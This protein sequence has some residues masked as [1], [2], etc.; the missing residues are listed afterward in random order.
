MHSGAVYEF[1]SELIRRRTPSGARRRRAFAAPGAVWKRVL[2]FEGCAPLFS[3]RLADAGLEREIPRELQL[4]LRD[5]RS[6]S[7]QSSLLIDRQMPAVA[8]MATEH[9]IRAMVL[10]GAARILGGETPGGR[11]VADVD[12]LV[13]PA[14]AARFHLLLQS[15]LGYRAAGA[16]AAHHLPGLV[17]PGC[18]GIEV[19]FRLAER[20]S[21]LDETIW[22]GT[23]TIAAGSHSIE[24][25][26][27]T[28]LLL[29]T[30][31]HAAA[32][33]WNVRYRLRD[34]CDV[35][36]LCGDDVSGERL[37]EYVRSHRERRALETLLS[38]AHDLEP[39][40]PRSRNGAWATVRRVSIA[41]LALAV[42][43]KERLMAERLFRYAGV[44]A[45]GSPRAILRSGAGIVRRLC[46]VAV[47]RTLPAPARTVRAVAALLIVALAGCSDPAGS[48]PE[49]A[50][51]FLFISNETAPRGIHLFEHDSVRRLSGA[52]HEDVHPHSAAGRI[53]FTSFRDGNA[54]IYSSDAGLAG[55]QRLTADPWS[56]TRPALDPSGTTIA[57][58]TNRTGA[59]RVW[60]MNADGTNQRALETGSGSFVPEGA[61]A[62]RGA[63][64]QIA[65][66]STRTGT[67]QVYV[68]ARTGGSAIQ[69]SHEAPGAFLP[70]WTGDGSAVLYTTEAGQATVR[71]V[72]RTGGDWRVLA[73]TD[74]PL[75]GASCRE[76]RC[77]S[78]AGVEGAGEIVIVERIGGVPRVVVGG[79]SDSSDSS[80]PAFLV[81]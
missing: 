57:F 45:E 36:E 68:V 62:W 66:T 10:K 81:R 69:L 6:K 23:R 22:E 65:F 27:A 67:S 40:L 39:R 58:V 30:L 50:P 64:N 28:S 75:R 12:L 37:A 11:S 24:I 16:G 4:L 9:G 51:P 78:V 48:R 33:N 73:S 56:D 53:V 7:L 76:T 72:P 13:R 55:Q 79:A 32:L 5:A 14:D 43:P 63:G 26:S 80:E 59:P 46:G 3:R 60:L 34:I 42:I 19:H 71:V 29:H 74:A 31:E 41:R 52:A 17:R 38:A 61:P 44:L 21:P 8:A 54:E 47:S 15:E 18:L 77:L 20:E 1:V 70:A 49:P 35:A 25:P 2:G